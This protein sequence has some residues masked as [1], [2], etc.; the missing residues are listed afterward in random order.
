MLSETDKISLLSSRFASKKSEAAFQAHIFKRNIKVNAWGIGIGLSVFILY[1]FSD[2]I[3]TVNPSR[4]VIVRLITFVLSALLFSTLLSPRIRKH[5]DLVIAVIVLLMC[6]SLNVILW[7]QPSLDNTWYLG[8]IQSYIMAAVLLRLS[9]HSMCL[10]VGAPFVQFVIVAGSMSE[11]QAALLQSTNVALVGVIALLGVYL[12]QRYQRVDFLKTQTISEQNIQLNALLKDARRDNQRKVAALNML[13]HFVKTPLHQISGFSDIVMDSLASDNDQHDPEAGVESARYI[14]EATA[15]LASS[16][17]SLLIYHRLDEVESR[18]EEPASVTSAIAD[19]GELI[20]A[21]IKVTT[22]G[23]TGEIRTSE[24]A[25][26]TAIQSLADY[27]NTGPVG[28]SKL[29]LT[30]QQQ[31]DIVSLML[32]DDGQPKPSQ[33]FVEET[34]PLTK[35]ENYLTSQGSDMP[36]ALRIVARASEVCGGEFLHEELPDGNAFTLTFRDFSSQMI[37]PTSVVA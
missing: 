13:V 2:F 1:I 31:D 23:S 37:V 25:V 16:V 18:K 20:E 6:S 10:V 7:L 14:K 8:L 34:K 32:R 24:Y 9:F 22:E 12:M 28:V 15:N 19:L 21:G 3:D 27:Y 4:P 29:M 30:L 26:K 17:N 33:Q 5:H 36:M 11:Q 35:I